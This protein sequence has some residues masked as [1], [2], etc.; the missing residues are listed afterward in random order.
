MDGNRG[1]TL[2]VAPSFM[3]RYGV[4]RTPRASSGMLGEL[5]V[6][7]IMIGMNNGFP[8]SGKFQK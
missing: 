7:L 5:V 1:A 8:L 4:H 2:T 6:A 3:P